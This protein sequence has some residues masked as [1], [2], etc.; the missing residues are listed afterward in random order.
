MLH[1]IQPLAVDSELAVLKTLRRRAFCAG[2]LCRFAFDNAE[3][4]AMLYRWYTNARC[5]SVC[6]LPLAIAKQ[7]A[8]RPYVT[9]QWDGAQVPATRYPSA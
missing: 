5:H 2:I 8:M 9:E 4:S 3:W 6:W 1:R 7:C